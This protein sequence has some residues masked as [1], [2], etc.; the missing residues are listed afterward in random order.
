[1]TEKSARFPPY[2]RCGPRSAPHRGDSNI[3]RCRTQNQRCPCF[4]VVHLAVL[5]HCD[6]EARAHGASLVTPL[7]H[8]YESVRVLPWSR[9]ERAVLHESVASLFFHHPYIWRLT[10][11]P[12]SH[13]RACKRQKQ[14]I[15]FPISLSQAH[16]LCFL[17]PTC[18]AFVGSYMIASNK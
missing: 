16:M 10:I 7:L 1:M 4:G 17:L 2:C 3:S 9:H 13:S 5:W 14:Q 18:H 11:F 6:V 15:G 8:E 12:P